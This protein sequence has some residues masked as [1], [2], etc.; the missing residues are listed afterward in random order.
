MVFHVKKKQSGPIF[1]KNIQNSERIPAKEILSG[2]IF[3]LFL[4]RILTREGGFDQFLR[5]D[6]HHHFWLLEAM[7]VSGGELKNNFTDY[8]SQNL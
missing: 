7:S 4:S 3:C 8:Y 2:E 1:L 5:L 6:S